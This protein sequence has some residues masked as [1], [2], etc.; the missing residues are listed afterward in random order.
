[1]ARITEKLR[2]NIDHCDYTSPFYVAWV[3][4]RGGWDFWLFAKAQ[5]WGGNV[6]REEDYEPYF[7]NL[8]TATTNTRTLLTTAQK[9][10]T[11]FAENVTTQEIQGL[12]TL[13]QSPRVYWYD[14]TNWQE[15]RPNKSSY[16]LYATD[17]NMHSFSL[18]FNLAR[19]NIP[20]N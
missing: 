8:S 14:G 4:D 15:I 20:T 13:I 16:N 1:M 6:N 5:E 7:P 9:A 18:S 19:T 11:V 12:E 2:I 17:G 3:N 10:V